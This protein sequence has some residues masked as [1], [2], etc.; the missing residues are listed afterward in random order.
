MA[1]AHSD[2]P[3]ADGPT[4]DHV[5]F[6]TDGSDD[7]DRAAAH[8]V[9]LAAAFDATLSVLSVVDSRY[10]RAYETDDARR[11]ARTRLAVEAEAATTRVT[12]RATA[13]GVRTVTAVE[14]GRPAQII[15]DVAADVDADVVVVGTHG[16]TG[17]YRFLLGSVAEGV[18]DRLRRSVLVVPTET[19]AGD[20]GD[21][22]VAYRTVLLATD[23]GRASRVATEWA[24]T[25]AAAT[26][27]TVRA[28]SVVDRRVAGQ[29][30]ARTALETEAREA[31]REAALA[32]TERGVEV[33]TAVEVG[34]PAAVVVDAAAEADLVVV[35]TNDRTG[36][37]RLAL[38]SVSRRVVRTTQT[39]VLVARRTET[40]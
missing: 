17:L 39:P 26:G 12:R 15:A 3:A 6:A 35:G 38:G 34:L 22:T 16:R 8:A 5:L 9:E 19:D 27:A 18:L 24:L 31:V 4:V 23:G 14:E 20:D 28:L 30:V 13:A 7:A 2:N 11:D 33:E 1:P 10:E 25:V 37:D 32:G 36:L 21:E 40:T 29:Q